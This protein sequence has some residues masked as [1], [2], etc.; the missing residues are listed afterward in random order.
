MLT[1]PLQ[2][3][4]CIEPVVRYVETQFGRTQSIITNGEAE[5]MSLLSGDGAPHVDVVFY[6]ILHSLVPCGFLW[7]C[8]Y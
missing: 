8:L 5:L 7:Q 1:E 2:F 6:V 3:L 4:E